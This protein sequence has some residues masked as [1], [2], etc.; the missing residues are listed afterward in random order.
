[1]ALYRLE[2]QADVGEV[3][4]V[5]VSPKHRGKGVARVLMDAIFEWASENNFGTIKATVAVSNTRALKFYARYGFSVADYPIPSQSK[6]VVLVKEVMGGTVRQKG[7]R[8]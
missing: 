1:M 4:Q 7:S 5:W 3:L 2:G 6:D 8:R